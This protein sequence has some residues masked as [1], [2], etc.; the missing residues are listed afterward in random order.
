ML[1]RP[2]EP[3]QYTSITYTSR[4]VEAEIE[5]ASV[6]STGDSY[7]NA[8][9]EALTKLF[10]KEVVWRNGPWSGRDS[11]EYAVMEWVHW[12]NNSRIHSRCSDMA[13]MAFEALH[14]TRSRRPVEARV[15]EPAL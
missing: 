14:Y 10:K 11:V 1:H 6:G 5:E 4:L 3:K 9:A 13:P 2:I 7:D 12:Y 8:A 15:L